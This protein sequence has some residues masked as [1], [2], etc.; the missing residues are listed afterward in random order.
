MKSAKK[1]KSWV[2]IVKCAHIRNPSAASGNAINLTHWELITWSGCSGR[3]EISRKK[4]APITE[5]GMCE[6]T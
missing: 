4:S 6:I 2:V 3:N 1:Q 5:I